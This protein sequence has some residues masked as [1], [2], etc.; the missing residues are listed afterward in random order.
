[1]PVPERKAWHSPDN[2]S[3]HVVLAHVPTARPKHDTPYL[4]SGHAGPFGPLCLHAHSTRRVMN[5]QLTKKAGKYFIFTR[6]FE[7][8]ECDD[9]NI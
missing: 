5:S 6:I 4:Y 8:T 9:H 2:S 7:P 1:M 3:C